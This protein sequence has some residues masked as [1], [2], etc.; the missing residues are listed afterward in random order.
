MLNGIF[1]K[2]QKNRGFWAAIEM[3]TDVKTAKLFSGG[4]GRD[5]LFFRP[6]M[7][8]FGAFFC[9]TFCVKSINILCKAINILCKNNKHSVQND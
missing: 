5:F 9:L 8:N 1:V 2:T 3:L 4:R 7:G 6:P